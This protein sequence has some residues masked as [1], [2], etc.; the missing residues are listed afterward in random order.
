VKA[1]GAA[2]VEKTGEAMNDAAKGAAEK[3]KN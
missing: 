3:M 2:A 1:A